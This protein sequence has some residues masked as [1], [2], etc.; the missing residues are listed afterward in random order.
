MPRGRQ[1]GIAFGQRTKQ[2]GQSD[3]EQ[4]VSLKRFLK[5]R[6]HLDFKREWYVGFGKDDGYLY[7]IDKQVGKNE[8]RRFTWRNPDLLCVDKSFGIIIVEL[9][10]AVHDRKVEA[11]KKRNELFRGAG[12]KLIVLNISDIRELGE[13]ITER[14]ECEMLKIVGSGCG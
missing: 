2:K 6:F 4:L 3:L 11:T 9:D 7:R 8:V 10:G 14:L 1:S 5:D 13:T 12:I